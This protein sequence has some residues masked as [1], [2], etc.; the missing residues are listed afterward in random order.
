MRNT[1][2]YHEEAEALRA[3]EP[4]QLRAL[5]VAFDDVDDAYRANR[6]IL[7]RLRRT[8]EQARLDDAAL[9]APGPHVQTLEGNRN[10]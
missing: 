9:G 8:P 6:A 7:E 2:D 3:A 1:R 5:L 10:A 4:G